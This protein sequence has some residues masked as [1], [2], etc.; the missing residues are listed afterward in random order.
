[1]TKWIWRES[2]DKANRRKHPIS[3]EFAET[4]LGDPFCVTRP[5]CHPDGDRWQTIGAPTT[6]GGLVLLV[7]HTEPV[8]LIDGTQVGRIVS[9]RR[10]NKQERR[11]Y[12][13][14]TSRGFA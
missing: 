11:I 12:E 6:Q 4:A 2:K 7:I 1:M 3:F 10:A 8:T 9:A 13:S 5:D 14:E